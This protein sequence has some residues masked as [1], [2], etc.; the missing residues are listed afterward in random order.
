MGPGTTV[1]TAWEAASRCWRGGSAS[2][3]ATWIVANAALGGV[4]GAGGA[5][6]QGIGGGIYTVGTFGVFTSFTVI[7]DNHA[8]TS[9]NNIGP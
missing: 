5:S 4:A 9:G 7:K 8:S 3:D 2:I 1:A 6:G